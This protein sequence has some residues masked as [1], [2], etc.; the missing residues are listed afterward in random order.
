M[1]RVG[2]LALALTM[3]TAVSVS[4]GE[5]FGKE[6]LIL[7]EGEE[8]RPIATV[9]SRVWPTVLIRIP[10]KQG[11]GA[12]FR[13]T[14]VSNTEPKDEA[15]VSTFSVEECAPGYYLETIPDTVEVTSAGEL[16]IK[17]KPKL[18]F[19]IPECV[20]EASELKGRFE[21][22]GPA[23]A[24]TPVDGKRDAKRSSP[25]CPRTQEFET[26]VEFRGIGNEVGGALP[27]FA[28]I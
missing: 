13:G 18:V 2:I 11:C 21:I 15:S 28:E 26:S 27:L 19:Q 1:R 10:G 25:T 22:P 7:R 16:T 23:Q 8:G 14:L 20:Y 6:P 12:S 3:L 9:G 17:G 4:A 5:A 24:E